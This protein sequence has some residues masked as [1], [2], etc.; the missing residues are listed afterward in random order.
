MNNH[1]TLFHFTKSGAT[2]SNAFF[3]RHLEKLFPNSIL[4]NKNK[5]MGTIDSYIQFRSLRKNFSNFL[6]EEQRTTFDTVE[7]K[8]KIMGHKVEGEKARY[9]GRLEPYKAFNILNSIEFEEGLN[10]TIIKEITHIFYED[11]TELEWLTEEYNWNNI[12]KVK[13]KKGRRV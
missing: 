8:E 12:S 6:F 2:A 5:N 1:T 10:F 4:N 11:R 3:K 7:N 13:Q 9:M